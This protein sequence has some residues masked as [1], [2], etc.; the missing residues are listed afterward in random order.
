MVCPKCGLP[1]ELCI[2]EMIAKESHKIRISKVQKRFGKTM[3]L[4]SGIDVSKI[5]VRQLLKTMKSKLACG[6]TYK[7]NE[8][9]L[10]GD[11]RARVKEIL[12]KEGFP[13]NIIEIA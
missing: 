2:C 7:N 1:Q 12:I 5:D 3:T 4:V 9:E 6:G 11:H 8:M 13:A 10:Q